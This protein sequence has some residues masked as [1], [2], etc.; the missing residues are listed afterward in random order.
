MSKCQFVA[1][2][3]DAKRA[4]RYSYQL[5]INDTQRTDKDIP[6]CEQ[7]AI[8]DPFYQVRN[9]VQCILTSIRFFD[10]ELMKGF[11]V[12]RLHKP[13]E[14]FINFFFTGDVPCIQFEKKIMTLEELSLSYGKTYLQNT[15]DWVLLGSALKEMGPLYTDAFSPVRDKTR[16]DA[17]QIVAKLFQ[18]PVVGLVFP[19]KAKEPI[20]PIKIKMQNIMRPPKFYQ[21]LQKLKL[22]INPVPLVPDKRLRG[23][24]PDRFE[25]R[26][27][28]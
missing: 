17:L 16:R 13:N 27:S 8:M 10:P 25:P 1:S 3:S 7:G 28:V 22:R 24:K 20:D 2:V 9:I 23:W 11:T 15:Q 18:D 19:L 5:G 26:D 4:M 12:K 14:N 21:I 6:Y